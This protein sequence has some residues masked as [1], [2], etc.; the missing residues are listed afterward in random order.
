MHVCVVVYLFKD[1]KN[2]VSS[3]SLLGRDTVR[4]INIFVAA[5][6]KHFYT[7][8]TKHKGIYGYYY[9]SGVYLDI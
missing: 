4:Y 3:N 7:D 8:S 2:V 9:N 6:H 5:E 1:L